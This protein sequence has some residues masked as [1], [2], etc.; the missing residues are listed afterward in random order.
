MNSALS[1]STSAAKE[2]RNFEYQEARKAD[3]R[4]EKALAALIAVID[5]KNADQIAHAI[6]ELL[7]Q[8]PGPSAP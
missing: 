8:S 4:T 6:H 3:R 2:A 7:R 5:E 1:A